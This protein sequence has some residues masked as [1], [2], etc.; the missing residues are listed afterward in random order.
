MVLIMFCFNKKKV[1][2]P[3]QDS[4]TFMSTSSY[5]YYYYYEPTPDTKKKEIDCPTAY[6]TLLFAQMKCG[7][8]A[9]AQLANV[10]SLE[11]KKRQKKK[12]DSRIC[13]PQADCTDKHLPR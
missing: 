8:K 3:L 5:Y 9:R 6:I 11:K 2:F 13:N 7:V 10:T 4:G 1:F 12:K